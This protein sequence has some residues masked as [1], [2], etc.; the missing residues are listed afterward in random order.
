MRRYP[1]IDIAACRTYSL[2]TRDNKVNV[3]DH[4]ARRPDQGMSFAEFFAGLP[5]LLGAD[6]QR[7]RADE[8][9]RESPGRS[10]HDRFPP[11]AVRYRLRRRALCS[12][13]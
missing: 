10:F 1:P 3:R 9:C 2:K 12:R 5:S 7:A 6:G 4:F 13:R 8:S 11:A